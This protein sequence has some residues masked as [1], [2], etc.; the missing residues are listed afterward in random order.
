[1]GDGFFIAFEVILDV[2]LAADEAAHLLPGG[3]A[4]DVVILD[5][6]VLLERFDADDES[7]AGDAQFHGLG[8]VTIDT[9]H[10][11]GDE[12]VALVIHK[13]VGFLIG[14][15]ADLFK[16]LH[17]VAFADHAIGRNDRGVTVQAS[18]GLR[19]FGDAAGLF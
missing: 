2:A 5:A 6:L 1:I 3:V 12:L 17:D 10:G 18:A 8:I 16:A 9:A 19:F 14:H 7:G 13:V 4:V 15:G 11:M